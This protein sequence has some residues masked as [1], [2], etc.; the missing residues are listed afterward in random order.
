MNSQDEKRSDLEAKAHINSNGSTATVGNPELE[1]WG[2]EQLAKLVEFDDSPDFSVETFSDEGLSEGFTQSNDSNTVSQSELFDE[3]IEGRTP[4]RFSSRPFPKAA[5]VGLIL[6]VVFGGGGLFLQG[7]MSSAKRKASTIANSPSPQSTPSISPSPDTE[8]GNLKTQLALRNQENQIKDLERSKTPKT[9]NTKTTKTEPTK[10]PNSTPSRTVASPKQQTPPTYPARPVQERYR[11]P[12]SRT[13]ESTR[14]V[15]ERYRPPLPRAAEPTRPTTPTSTSAPTPLSKQQTIDPMQQWMVLSQL[16]SFGMISGRESGK[17]AK[18]IAPTTVSN[19]TQASTGAKVV[20]MPRAVPVVSST[21]NLPFNSTAQKAI[22]A[23]QQRFAIA[24]AQVTQNTQDTSVSAN[25]GSLGHSEDMGTRGRKDVEN[26]STEFFRITASPPLGVIKAAS[27]NLS[28]PLDTPPVVAQIDPNEEASILNGMAVR[29]LQ[30]GTQA[31]GQLVTPLVWA[32]TDSTGGEKFVVQL[33]EPMA[34][35]PQ[36]TTIVFQV[37]AVSESGLV[38]LKATSLVVNGQEYALPPGAISVRGQGG[39]PLIADKWGDKGPAIAS[40][41]VTAFL[42]GSL[43]KVGE[44]LNKPDVQQSINS[45]SG[46][47]SY[48][49]TTNNRR[50]NLLGAVLEGGFGPLTDKILQRNEQA[51]QEIM[52]RPNVWYIRA[53]ENVQVFVNQSF[54]L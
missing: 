50:P 27:T 20:T 22:C 42:F 12:L 21:G 35:L 47:F 17:K 14:P 53:G 16:G 19:S 13:V 36:G 31:K 43:S 52:S 40:R 51:I 38:Q 5:V 45:S 39:Q 33:S 28:Q 41:D 46:G 7:V 2:D 8:V 10:T 18:G 48:S 26:F 44:V 9:L 15:Q 25:S 32:K 4:P 49:T 37:A 54:E 34:N 29:S 11:P 1:K 3:P 23:S 6:L 24:P 30:V